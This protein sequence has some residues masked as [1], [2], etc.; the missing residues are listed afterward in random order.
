MPTRKTRKQ[1]KPKKQ[2]GSGNLPHLIETKPLIVKMY[3]ELLSYKIECFKNCVNYICEKED[4]ATCEQTKRFLQ[5]KPAA[6]S[7]GFCN[8]MMAGFPKTCLTN[9]SGNPIASYDEC[10]CDR[11]RKALIQFEILNAKLA[12]RSINSEW[13]SLAAIANELLQHIRMPGRTLSEE[14]SKFIQLKRLSGSRSLVL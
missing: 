5:E 13:T 14:A 6:D 12:R 7:S 9:P 10:A 8:N 4:A 2:T 1:R 11:F 3:S